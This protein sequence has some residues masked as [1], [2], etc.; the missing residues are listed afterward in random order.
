LAIY[1][2]NTDDMVHYTVYPRIDICDG[3]EP[4][5][6]ELL[7]G[8]DSRNIDYVREIGGA[9]NM[10]LNPRSD[11]TYI[12]EMDEISGTENTNA[13]Q[14]LTKEGVLLINGELSEVD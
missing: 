10:P 14:E 3:T 2:G 6:E 7:T 4:T 11:I 5:L 9:V 1:Q 13:S 12:T 8:H